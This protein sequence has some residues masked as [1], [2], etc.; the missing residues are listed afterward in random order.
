MATVVIP[1][2]PPAVSALDPDPNASAVS[3]ALRRAG[4]TTTTKDSH[5][6]VFQEHSDAWENMRQVLN[7]GEVTTRREPEYEDL[8][9][10][11]EPG[12]IPQQSGWRTPGEQ[13]DTP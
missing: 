3:S 2:P 13:V 8:P 5:S 12:T 6:N 11:A 9:V 4:R 1:A 7:G 10:F